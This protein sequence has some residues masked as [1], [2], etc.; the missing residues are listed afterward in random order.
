MEPRESNLVMYLDLALGHGQWEAELGQVLDDLDAQVAVGG[1][2]VGA[3][4]EGHGGRQRHVDDGAV[5]VDD[6][7]DRLDD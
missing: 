4:Q 6:R 7:L 1:V 5:L 3:A 2:D